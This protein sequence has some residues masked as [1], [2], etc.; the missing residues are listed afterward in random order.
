MTRHGRQ[1]LLGLAGFVVFGIAL[2]LGSGSLVLVTTHGVSM[3]PMFHTGDLAVVV[4]SAE[5]HVGEVVAYHSPLLHIVVLHRII[6]ERSGLFT[7][8]GDN[9]HFLDPVSVPM[10]AIVGRL[11]LHI[12]GAGAVF[13]RAHSPFVIAVLAALAAVVV[14]APG[15]A[16]RRRERWRHMAGAARARPL[17]A[18]PAKGLSRTGHAV[19]SGQRE[20]SAPPPLPGPGAPTGPGAP[21]RVPVLDLSLPDRV[22]AF[23]K[24]SAPGRAS[25]PAG[26]ARHEGWWAVLAL[27]VA[28]LF[29]SAGA[30]ALA[31][32][33]TR[34]VTEPVSYGEEA[35]FSY[36]A[37]AQPGVTY[38]VGVVTTGLPVFPQLVRVVTF[39]AGYR[40][41][42]G[43]AT[44]GAISGEIS[45][46]ALLDGPGGW[47]GTVATAAPRG[48]TG[49][50]AQ[51]AVSV[52]FAR[53]AAVESTFAAETGLPLQDATLVVAV[54]V[55]V[56]GSVA[57]VLFATIYSPSLVMDYSAQELTLP[58]DGAGGNGPQFPQL[59]LSHTASVLKP[60]RVPSTVPLLG[61]DVRVALVRQAGLAGAAAALLCAAILSV[62][63]RR[64]RQMDE[65]TWIR[66]RYGRELV[67]V[68][69]V[70]A[71]DGRP[72][73]DIADFRHLVR[74]ARNYESLVLEHV[75]GAVHNYY[76]EMGECVYRYQS[77]E[78][79][80]PPPGGKTP[81]DRSSRPSEDEAP[82]LRLVSSGTAPS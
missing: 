75:A 23:D 55:V 80:S 1:V 16:G 22:P 61:R 19:P 73:V 52:D 33:A 17:H 12:P 37:R 69:S 8:K 59:H 47:T 39:R 29:G 49:P 30:A 54:K 41:S 74:L 77:G 62:W 66:A 45:A 42:G 68:G 57:G 20:P 67:E 9:N 11:V 7:F 6:A 31:R 72:V 56:R 2:A 51:V 15:V 36:S 44:P 46:R 18:A 26:A 27:G 32:P 79:S 70:P 25:L 81:R 5:Y 40:L 21:D 71:G 50:R 13:D 10:S 38:P 78:G 28:L 76:V 48:F 58:D 35:T 64:R 53:I 34:A 82:F 4:P 24:P 14:T 43:S 3:E 60:A 65:P 63:A